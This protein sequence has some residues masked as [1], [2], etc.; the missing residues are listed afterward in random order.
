MSLQAIITQIPIMPRKEHHCLRS[1]NFKQTMAHIRATEDR[2]DDEDVLSGLLSGAVLVFRP[3]CSRYYN[4]PLRHLRIGSTGSLPLYHSM[5]G[6]SMLSCF[7]KAKITDLYCTLGP[8]LGYANVIRPKVGPAP[9]S[10]LHYMQ[11]R[12]KAQSDHMVILHQLDKDT[13]VPPFNIENV[14][15]R[16]TEFNS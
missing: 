2:D 1:V 16:R 9:L 8:N 6:L 7:A 4:L 5:Y 12:K 13:A 3:E 15:S 11:S 10:N 14:N